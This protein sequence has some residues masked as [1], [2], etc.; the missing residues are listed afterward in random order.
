MTCS[1]RIASCAVIAL[2]LFGQDSQPT[3]TVEGSVRDS[4]GKSVAAADVDLKSS[5][6][7]FTA[8]TNAS[9]VYRF[10]ALPAGSYKLRVGVTGQGEA[11]SG[12]FTLASKETRIIDLTLAAPKPEFF[13]QPTF[14]VA[15]VSDNTSRGGH[16]SDTVLRSSE[17]LAKATASLG[18]ES[19]SP[20]DLEEQRGN[21]LEAAR[22]YERTAQRDPTERNLFDWAAELLAH[23]ANAQAIEVFTRG[24]RL[25]PHST[26]MLLGLAVS[27]YASGDYD[28]AAQRFFEAAD[29][30][31]SDPSPYLFLGKV[32]SGAI[33][34]SEGF[35]ERMRRFATL[36]PENAQAN[37]YYARS[38]WN[39]RLA[40]DASLAAQVHAL[41][42]NA[43]R[44]DP[45]FADAYL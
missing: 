15:G 39:R 42:E 34:E 29:L 24:N 4:A 45:K 26:R 38:L 19:L 43:I 32:R 41:L 31:P 5:S 13:D 11:A 12:P 8:R 20:A 25:F 33:T 9:G 16:G 21:A 22:E 27:H 6:Q 14:I 7:T 1:F 36:Q 37:Y 28:Q 17:D 23:R 30:N 2:A 44:V 10:D 3:A 40:P 18:K 35:S